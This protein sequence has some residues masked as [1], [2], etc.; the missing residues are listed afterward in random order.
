MA[1]NFVWDTKNC[2]DML[3]EHINSGDELI[4]EFNKKGSK[5]RI[6]LKDRADKFRF[7]FLKKSKNSTFTTNGDDSNGS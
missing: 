3:V 5:P 2:P 6:I 1:G 4:L 7:S